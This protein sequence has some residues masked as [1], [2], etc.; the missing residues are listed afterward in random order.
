[1][2]QLNIVQSVYQSDREV[3]PTKLVPP[4]ISRLVPKGQKGDRPFV[5]RK[6]MRRRKKLTTH[7]STLASLF[8]FSI[9]KPRY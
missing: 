3:S 2:P 9:K 8:M 1:M 7:V 5:K 4:D 6:E